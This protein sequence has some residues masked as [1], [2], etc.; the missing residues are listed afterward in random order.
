RARIAN[1][2][3]YLEGERIIDPVG[4]LIEHGVG[5]SDLVTELRLLF[6]ERFEFWYYFRR[7]YGVLP[8]SEYHLRLFMSAAD[9]FRVDL[10]L[11]RGGLT[12]FFSLFKKLNDQTA[13]VFNVDYH[14]GG[15]MW[16]FLRSRYTFERVFESETGVVYYLVQ[17]RFEPLGGFRVTF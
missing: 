12:G 13:L 16:V 17:R 4:S 11:D 10:G 2:R 3:D 1:S 9:R 15:H 5:G 7:H 14:V 8:L 6:F